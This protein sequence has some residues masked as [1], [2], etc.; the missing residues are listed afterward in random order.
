MRTKKARDVGRALGALQLA[1]WMAA[2]QVQSGVIFLDRSGADDADGRQFAESRWGTSPGEAQGRP[3]SSQQRFAS[4]QSAGSAER[5]PAGLVMMQE[6]PRV[7]DKAPSPFGQQS[8]LT[9]LIPDKKKGVQET[10]LIAGDLGYFPKTLFVSQNIPVRLFVTGASKETL[11][12][13]VDAFQVR[14][15]VRAQRIEEI[16][17]TP[18][19]PGKY[20]IHCPINQMEATLV[21]RD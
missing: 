12:V 10:A 13:M 11:C 2:A 8:D 20:R 1:A 15:Q 19:A 5:N 21:V 14:K 6:L 4:E 3:A 9:S 17:F 16:T 18:S 7:E